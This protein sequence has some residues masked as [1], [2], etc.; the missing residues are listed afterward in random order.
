M[1][2]SLGSRRLAMA[3]GFAALDAA[4]SLSST[5][6]AAPVTETFAFTGTPQS[7][8]V[9]ADVCTVTVVAVGAQG[10]GP[11][12]GGGLGGQATAELDVVAGETLVI[13]VGGQGHDGH[14]RPVLL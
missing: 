8:T 3:A 14:L 9:P 6:G 7:F 1:F 4:L 10:G 11:Q 12:E 2:S 13:E 5:A